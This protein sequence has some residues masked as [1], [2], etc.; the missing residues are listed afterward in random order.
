MARK[1][2]QEA[3]ETRSSIMDAAVRV[4]AV[5][6]VARTSLDDI[7][8][9]AGVTRGAIYWHFANKADLLNILW[10]QILLLYAPMAQAS[11]AQNEPD[12]LGKMKSLYLALFNGLVE[13]QHQQQ[14]FRLLFD[15][16]SHSRETEAMR[17]R[18]IQ[19]RRE[20]LHGIQIALNNA[21]EKGQLPPNLDVRLGAISVLVFIHGLIANWTTTP[22]MFDIKKEGE[23]FIEGIFQMLRTGFQ[24]RG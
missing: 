16:S 3:Q 7:A 11:E 14:L 12:P 22:D 1:T 4:F 8:R 23:R 5:K 20:R 10:D 2:K 15:D 6:G 17:L 19:M 21:K 24:E 18:H 13:D 9:E